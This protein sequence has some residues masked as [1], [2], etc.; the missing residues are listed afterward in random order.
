[1]LF[2]TLV[3][4]A[5]S[6]SLFGITRTNN[7][8]SYLYRIANIWYLR[9]FLENISKSINNLLT[10]FLSIFTLYFIF[11][12]NKKLR[13]SKFQYEFDKES[14]TI[15]QSIANQ[16]NYNS[17]DQLVVIIVILIS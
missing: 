17:T 16:G 9:H 3:L 11:S 1:M 15:K 14:T 12:Q 10:L 13:K 2:V 8:E 7:N 4:F 6:Y 5:I